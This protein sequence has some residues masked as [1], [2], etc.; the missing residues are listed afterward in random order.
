MKR[1]MIF[2]G[3]ALLAAG[4]L[5]AFLSCATSPKAY[6][7][8][9]AAFRSGSYEKALAV[10]NDDKSKVRKTNY[11]SKN[12]ILLYLDRG[13]IAHYAGQHKD[14]SQ[15]LET[16]ER[17]IEEAFTKSITQAIG[18]YILNDNTKDYAGED[19]EDLYTNVFNALNY[20][21]NNDLEGALVEIRRL[22]EKL[23]Y[24]ADKYER[25]KKKVLDSNDQ[26]DPRQL[27][28]EASRFSNSALARYL[29]ILF[30]RAIGKADDVR[31]DY[32]EFLRAYELAP[33]VYSNLVP[34]SVA[35]E[36][37]VP[38]GKGRLN[39]IAFTGLSPVKEEQ[40]ILIPLPLPFP[41]NFA[42][43][44]FPKMVNRANSVQRAEVV[45]DNGE[46]FPLELVENM[47]AVAEE[48]FKSRLG[49]I[50]LKTTLRTIIKNTASI[51]ASAAVTKSSNEGFGFLAGVVGKVITEASEKADTRLSRYFPSHALVGGINLEPGNTTV[52]VNFYGS[53]GLISSERREVRAREN[54]LNLEEFI[55]LR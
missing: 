10:L 30:Y 29:G 1:R 55:C 9:D 43:L 31:I 54:T 20:Y 39:L 45:L 18:S 41:N 53:G 47:S 42:R 52:T 28:M 16:A 24:L 15:D 48:T 7:E 37:S 12:E 2:N 33:E 6:E 38:P 14:S 49:L 46:R 8:V 21:H 40:N 35:D 51:T 27:P 36:L 32:E 19:Y 4:L 50:I 34:S 13:M 5:F 26:V 23:Q 25:A 3:P 17:L 44:E 22:N 11:P